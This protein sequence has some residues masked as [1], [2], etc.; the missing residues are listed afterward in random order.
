MRWA[1]EVFQLPIEELLFLLCD[2]RFSIDKYI[3]LLPNFLHHLHVLFPP[4][5]A[6]CSSPTNSVTKKDIHS[7]EDSGTLA[8]DSLV[9]FSKVY[10]VR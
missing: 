10:M 1:G 5:L 6:P 2:L 4:S 8:V 3:I 9:G 7:E